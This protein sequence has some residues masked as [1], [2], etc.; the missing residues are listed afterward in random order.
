MS[1]SMYIDN[2]GEDILILGKI[3]TQ[4]LNNTTLTV[5]TQYS[6]Y[7]TRPN[8]NF[9]LSL[10]YNGSNSFLFVE[11]IVFYLLMLRKYI[12]SKQKILKRKNIY[13]LFLGNVL[14][15]FSANSIK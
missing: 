1:L 12:N 7:F 5:E 8:G 11:A 10:H 3:T 4:T 15:H 2:K 9:C 14:G 13:P 6:L